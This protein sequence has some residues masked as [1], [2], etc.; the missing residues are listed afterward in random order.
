[1]TDATSTLKLEAALAEIARLGDEGARIFTRLYADEAREAAR[2]ADAR[3]DAGRA[4]GP[5]D[6]RLVSIKDLFDVAGE[7]TTAGSVVR[8]GAAPA[9]QDA[10]VVR[11]LR[12]AGAVIVGKT[13]MTEFAF[14]GVGVNPHYGTPGNARDVTRIPGGSSSG[15]GASAG[16]GLVEFAIGSDTGGSVRIPSALNGLVGFKPT[17]A[18]VSREG[19][20]PL[21]YTLDTVGP[22][23]HSVA[24][25]AAADAVLAGQD[26]MTLELRTTRSL[27]VGVPRG[28]LFTQAQDEVLAAFEK[29]LDVLSESGAEIRDEA[30]D[31]LL[32]EPFRLQER[33]TMIAAEAAWIHQATV[34]TQA[35]A[36]DPIVLSRIRKGQTIGAA[37]YVGMQQARAALLP[38]LDARLVDLDVLVL[39]TVPV[40]AP[41]IADVET[42][43]AFMKLNGLLLRNPSVFNF[44]DLPA[45]SLPLQVAGGLPVGLM[46]VGRRGR[47]RELL[48]VGAAIEKVLASG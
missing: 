43:E 15:A 46:V 10:I 48:A 24:D 6:G 21:S 4:L 47:D 33:G 28:L 18:R 23:C 7:T 29:A 30:L 34:A 45:L 5:L 40:L 42:E 2:A 27:R 44:Y 41:R 26:A 20:Y 11:R 38:Q 25:A 3:R 14:S 35:D 22:L 1:M 19:A 13:N 12:A 17:Q 8:R 37:S 39:P 9:T 32:G 16:R 36:Y 31:D